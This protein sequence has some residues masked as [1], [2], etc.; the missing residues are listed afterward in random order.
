MVEGRWIIRG[1]LALC[2]ALSVGVDRASASV[3]RGL[4]TAAL[5]GGDLTDTENNG[6]P[7]NNVNYNATFAASEEPNFGGSEGALNVFDNQ[8]AG[9]GNSKFCC[10]DQN[11]FP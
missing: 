6:D 2:V 11:N 10:G 9:G 4:G 3:V 1:V 8:A 7:E 5:R